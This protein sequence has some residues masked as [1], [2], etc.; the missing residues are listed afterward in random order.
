MLRAVSL[1]FT[2]TSPKW[3]QELAIRGLKSCWCWKLSVFLSVVQH[4]KLFQ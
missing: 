3:K 2:A 1:K 4:K